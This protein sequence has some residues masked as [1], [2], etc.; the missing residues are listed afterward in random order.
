M[1]GLF[2]VSLAF[3]RAVD[4]AKVNAFRVFSV[5]HFDSVA[6]E[7]ARPESEKSAAKHAAGMSNAVSC[8]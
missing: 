6:V 1:Q 7:D 3:L 4:A 8:R 5:A 2:A